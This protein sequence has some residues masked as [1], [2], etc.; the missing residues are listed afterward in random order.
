[1]NHEI[2]CGFQK[3]NIKFLLFAIQVCNFPYFRN[4]GWLKNCLLK[5]YNRKKVN[6]NQFECPR[7]VIDKFYFLDSVSNGLFD[8]RVSC[9]V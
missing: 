9:F 8:I 1:M 6:L 4:Y 5:Y 7:C 3:F 2:V